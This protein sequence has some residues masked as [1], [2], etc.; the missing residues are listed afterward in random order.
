VAASVSQAAVRLAPPTPPTATGCLQYLATPDPTG[1]YLVSPNYYQRV[2]AVLEHGP[3]G[4]IIVI[5]DSLTW[6]SA[7]HTAEVLRSAG[8]GPVCVS[9]TIGATV[10]FGTAEIPDGLDAIARIRSSAAIWQGPEVK[11]VVA[12]GTNDSGFAKASLADAKSYVDAMVAAIGP[13]TQPI[14]WMTVRTKRLAPWPTREDLF[15]QAIA[16]AGLQL[17]PWAAT[18]QDT[19]VHSDLVHLTEE[20]KAARAALYAPL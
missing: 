1:M 9:G 10:Q 14:G 17:L 15:N 8:W 6:L 2:A 12:L 4:P 5:G 7:T 18:F 3:R 11:V 19:W 13:T 20:G 16:E